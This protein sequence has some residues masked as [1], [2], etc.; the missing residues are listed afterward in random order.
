MISS[1]WRTSMKNTTEH[2][3]YTARVNTTSCGDEKNTDANRCDKIIPGGRRCYLFTHLVLGCENGQMLCKVNR[4][5]CL[6]YQSVC[7]QQC[8]DGWK[9]DKEHRCTVNI[10]VTVVGLLF[11]VLAVMSF[12]MFRVCKARRNLRGRLRRNIRGS[13]TNMQNYNSSI[14]TVYNNE[15]P[16]YDVIENSKLPEYTPQDSPP[17]YED[18]NQATGCSEI[19]VSIS[20]QNHIGL[21]DKESCFRGK[22]IKTEFALLLA[23]SNHMTFVY[24]TAAVSCT[25]A[26]NDPNLCGDLEDAT[27]CILYPSK[28]INCTAKNKRP[29]CDVTRK[30]CVKIGKRC[31]PKCC[32]KRTMINGKCSIKAGRQHDTT[33]DVKHSIKVTAPTIVILVVVAVMLVILIVL[34]AL[35]KLGKAGQYLAHSRSPHVRQRSIQRSQENATVFT[36]YN[37]EPPPYEVVVNSN[38]PEYSPRDMP[39]LYKEKEDT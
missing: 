34:V 1:K 4:T 17:S 13:A 25:P 7:T 33:D 36:V 6:P 16:P 26:E 32:D 29:F 2:T 11:I 19:S 24:R 12:A 35:I 15:P 9:E 10:C 20:E 8:C 3:D 22:N 5:L 18:N 27:Q 30:I 39:P 21:N 23:I 14:Y 38:L 28:A 37:N 31:K